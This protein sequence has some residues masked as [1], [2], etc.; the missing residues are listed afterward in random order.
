MSNGNIKRLA[1]FEDTKPDN[2]TQ[3]YVSTLN[4]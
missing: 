4:H 2:K 1:P 3:Y